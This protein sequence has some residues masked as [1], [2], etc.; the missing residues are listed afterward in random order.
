MTGRPKIV[1]GMA[2]LDKPPKP[3]R[4]QR[5]RAQ[6]QAKAWKPAHRPRPLPKSSLS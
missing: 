1:A 5:I 4:A 3:R 2:R 6:R